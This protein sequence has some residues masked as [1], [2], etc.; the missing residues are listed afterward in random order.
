M[1]ITN[2]FKICEKNVPG[3]RSRLF[4]ANMEDIAS[5]T[6]QG[7]EL[8]S[9]TMESQKHFAI[10]E[11]DFDAVQYESAGQANRGFFCEQTLT[12]WF[13]YYRQE[14]LDLFD[15]LRDAAPCGLVIIRQDGNGQYWVSGIAPLTKMGANRPWLSVETNFNTGMSIEDIDEGGRAEVIFGRLSATEEYLL[16]DGS[17]SIALSLDE[18]D[19][20]FV[21]WPS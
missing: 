9:I 10:I 18:G 16:E 3:N 21:E 4:V 2:F 5:Y 15:E 11:A 19:A 12:A 6:F 20:A 14:V 8:E 17:G 13:T 1:S 7:K